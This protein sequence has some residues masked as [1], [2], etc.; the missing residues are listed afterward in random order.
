LTPGSIVVAGHGRWNNGIASRQSINLE[1]QILRSRLDTRVK[2]AY[3]G[4]T[5]RSIPSH[6]AIHAH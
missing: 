1:K 4:A 5:N 3:D 6:G 2:P